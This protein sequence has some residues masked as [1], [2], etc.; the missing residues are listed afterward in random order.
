VTSHP[1]PK[2]EDAR[3]GADQT[4]P[5]L[6]VGDIV[7][8]IASMKSAVSQTISLARSEAGGH[9]HFAN[10]WSVV[11]ARDD[12]QARSAF[13]EGVCY[14]DGLPVVWA[15][16]R[17]GAGASASRVEGPR[18]FESV[19]DT[20]RPA[21]LR[22][23]LLGATPDTLRLLQLSLESRYPGALIVGTSSPPFAPL[24]DEY[25]AK[26]LLKVDEARPDIVWVGLGTPKQDLFAAMAAPGRSEVFACVGA[27]FDMSAGTLRRAPRWMQRVGLEWLYRFAQE[28]R[29][30]W[31]R[32][33]YGNLKF[34]ALALAM[35]R[36]TDATA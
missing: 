19:I 30:L 8:R 1:H 18:F 24:D 17:G 32:Y 26:E 9:L 5:S 12:A 2:K 3:A 33:T 10:A 28:P 11:T 29:R 34:L 4:A 15:M 35:S 25:V 31:R 13:A 36:T 6:P 7:F 16:R 27:A 23:Y 21:G 14:P 22:H 20:G